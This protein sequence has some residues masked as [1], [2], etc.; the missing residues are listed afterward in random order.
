[1]EEDKNKNRQ[2][3]TK[4]KNEQTQEDPANETKSDSD[5]YKR[6]FIGT[7]AQ[8]SDENFDNTFRQTNEKDIEDRDN[9]DGD[10]NTENNF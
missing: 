3:Q 7:G 2:D 9:N 1:M 10:A 5:F 6:T 8:K 4:T